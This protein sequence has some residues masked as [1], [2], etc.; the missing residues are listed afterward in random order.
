MST[1]RSSHWPHWIVPF[2]FTFLSV[3]FLLW[4]DVDDRLRPWVAR[5]GV[6]EGWQRGVDRAAGSV[7]ITVLTTLLV[8]LYRKVI[9]NLLWSTIHRKEFLVGWWVYALETPEKEILG[10]FRLSQSVDQVELEE[11][12]CYYYH[13]DGEEKLSRRGSWTSHFMSISKGI[14]I[15]YEME[16]EHTEPGAPPLKYLGYLDLRA[17]KVEPVVGVNPH[18]GQV[19]PVRDHKFRGKIYCERLRWRFLCRHSERTLKQLLARH[20][21]SLLSKVRYYV[22]P[23]QTKARAD[24]I[25]STAA[26]QIK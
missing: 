10:Y 5:L 7:V 4:L 9:W 1:T 23:D 13:R 11:A 19:D 16:G 26:P 25:S 18:Q 3:F 8:L 15:V 20:S 17:N 2:A 24:T 21:E 22:E 14:Q 6:P 12:Q